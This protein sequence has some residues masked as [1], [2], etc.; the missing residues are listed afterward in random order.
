MIICP[1]LHRHAISHHIHSEISG[2]LHIELHS[3]EESQP[4]PAGTCAL[5]THFSERILKDK[6]DFVVLPCDFIPPPSLTLSKILDKFRSD[7]IF[8]DSVATT[9]WFSTMQQDK[10]LFPDEWGSQSPSSIMWDAQS[11]TLLYI[12]SLDEVDHNPDTFEL[13]TSIL[14]R[15]GCLT[16]SS[17]SYLRC[18]GTREL[19]YPAGIK[20]LMCMSAGD[21][22]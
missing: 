12:D 11:G 13:K 3:Y 14:S 9:C 5:L 21:P 6:Q 19:D 4:S 1:S 7:S 8:E 16:A 17:F 2:S 20:T 15:F 10:G 18:A 22:S